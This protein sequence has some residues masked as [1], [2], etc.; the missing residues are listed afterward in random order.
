VR[1][2]VSTSTGRDGRGRAVR[3]ATSESDS[4]SA[5]ERPGQ[6]RARELV[7][8]ISDARGGGTVLRLAY[9]GLCGVDHGD[10]RRG[11]LLGCG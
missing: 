10:V 7:E 2:A 4:G 5:V 3:M 8:A 6:G 11:G 1:P 9:A